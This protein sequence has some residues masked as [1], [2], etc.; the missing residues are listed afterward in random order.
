MFLLVMVLFAHGAA[1][2]ADTLRIGGVDGPDPADDRRTYP[3][4]L[5]LSGGGARGL[6]SIG[7]LKAFEEKGIRV[8]AV[9]GTSMGG[10]IGGLYACG[11]SP[12]DL[13]RIMRQTDFNSLFTNEPARSTMFLTQRQERDRHLLSIRFRGLRP[14]I[15]QGLTAGQKLTSLLAEL[16]LPATYRAG[17]DFGRFRIPFKAVTT[18]V[19]SGNM[20]V[21]SQGSLAEAMRATMAF[22][23]AFTGLDR[24]HQLLMDGGMVMPIPVEIV[25]QMCDSVPLVVAV[26]TTSPLLPKEELSTPV[27]IAN[28][29]T[30]IMVADQLRAQLHM[31]DF[32]LQPVT[33]NYTSTSFAEKESIID[34]GYQAGLLAADSIIVLSKA[35][36]EGGR[37]VVNGIT[38]SSRAAVDSNAIAQ[39][40]VGLRFNRQELADSLKSIT[41]QYGLFEIRAWFDQPFQGESNSRSEA[42]AAKLHIDA[43]PCLPA[44][45][46]RFQFQGISSFTENELLS[47]MQLPDTALSPPVL[48]SGLMR[49]IDHYRRDGHDLA[50]IKHPEVV[51]DSSLVRVEIDE[52]I[53]RRIVVKQNRH[54]RDWF[55]RSYLPLKAGKPYSTGAAARGIAD[56]YGTDLFDRVGFDLQPAG[57]SAVM[58]I[59]V[60]EKNYS[61]VRLGWHWH[62]E[63]KSEEFAELLNDNWLG[64][65]VEYQMHGRYSDRRRELFGELKAN[66]IFATYLTGQ[67]RLYGTRLVRVMY[68]VEGNEQGMRTEKRFG[69]FLRFGQQIARLGTVTGRFLREQ[70]SYVSGDPAVESHWQRTSFSLES[71]VETLDRWPFPESGKK[72]QFEL[73]AAV[74]FLGGE[75]QYTRLHW[76][77]EAYFPISARLN[78]HPRFALGWSRDGLPPSERFYVGGQRSF[79]G[80][81]TDRLSGDKMILVNQEL[82]LALPL[83]FYAT[84]QYDLGEVYTITDD[85]KLRNL[86]HG[87]GVSL[88]FDSPLGPVELGYGR[89]ENESD[90]LYFSAGLDF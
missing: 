90:R 61:Q 18:D 27:D 42:R 77:V 52:A 54:T 43:Y 85:I 22:P 21:L 59:T 81:R 82:R 34:G 76:S 74:K 73:E 14:H 5:A 19:A 6:A 32:V 31:A 53:I 39:H 44:S 9:A 57:D 48:R 78:Y 37:L 26:N 10:V 30:T 40:F 29:V 50:N 87:L 16:T 47:I 36:Q 1:M 79:A 23:L 55:V 28:Q 17:G 72:H 84:A 89:A 80:Y 38:L 24:D 20:V 68:D 64:M 60:D 7:V 49:I 69:G 67:V 45:K 63:Y 86:R 35:M 65:G 33:D 12:D 15:P 83:R 4:L 62:D 71:L 58:T 70:V 88:A 11:Y 66:R 3:V 75:A 8:A 56:I 2:G 25:R 13:R 41:R 46:V 51:H